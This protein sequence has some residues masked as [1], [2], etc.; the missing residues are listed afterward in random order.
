[1][2]LGRGSSLRIDSHNNSWDLARSYAG[3]EENLSVEILVVVGTSDFN[4]QANLE[5]MEHLQSLG[6]SFRRKVVPDVPHSGVRL[7]QES[8]DEIMRFHERC[9]ARIGAS[10]NAPER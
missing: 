5:W 4:Y 3:R 7:Y 6:I 9:F 8:G 10:S 1:M 2:T